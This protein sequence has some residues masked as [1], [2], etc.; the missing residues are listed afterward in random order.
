M[1]SHILLFDKGGGRILQKFLSG[2]STRKIAT[3]FHGQKTYCESC[4]EKICRRWINMSKKGSGKIVVYSATR[5]TVGALVKRKHVQESGWKKNA[6]ARPDRI[7]AFKNTLRRILNQKNRNSRVKQA[8]N[9]HQNTRN[10][11]FK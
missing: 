10:V 4:C 2:E 8:R 11:G 6:N 5:R 3:Y 7:R 9:K 1:V